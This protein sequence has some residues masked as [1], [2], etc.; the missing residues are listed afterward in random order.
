MQELGVI[1]GVEAVGLFQYLQYRSLDTG[2]FVRALR[3]QREGTNC[4]RTMIRRR[5]SKSGC[6]C[7]LTAIG[8]QV[9][10]LGSFDPDL[11]YLRL[12]GKQIIG[13]GFFPVR[14]RR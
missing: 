3:S 12:I 13:Q 9:L 1:S 8:Q 6:I 7:G 14:A 11:E 10:G 5:Y 4:W 2:K